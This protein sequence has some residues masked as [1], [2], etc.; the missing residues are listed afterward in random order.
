MARRL[1]FLGLDSLPPR[2]LYGD[3]SGHFRY[4]KGLAGDGARYVMRSCHPPI[5]IPAWLVMLT[6]KSPGELGIYGFRHR[7][8]G[9]YGAHI[10]NS[11]YVRAETLWDSLGK[12]GLRVGLYG[13]PP[14]YPPRPVKGF[15]VSDFTTPDSSAGYT[16][17]PWLKRE[18]EAAVGPPIFDIVYR[19]GDKERAARDVMAMLENHLRQVEYLATAKSW[20][21]FFYVEIAVDRAHH[22]FWRF[23]DPQHPRYEEHPTFSKV[24]PSLYERIDSWFEALH[25]KLPKDTIIVIASDHGT[26]A[27]KGA[28]VVNQWLVEQGFL[29]LKKDLR[30]LKPGTDLQEELVDWGRT[31]AWA[32]GGYYSR[33]FVNVKG[34]EPEGAVEPGAFDEVVEALRS[35]LRSLRGPRGEQWET[36][37]VRPAEVYPRAEGDAPDLMVYFDNLSWRAAGTLG[38]PS[39]YLPEN[40]RGPDDAVHDW[41]GVLAI[42]D[43]EGTV[44]NSDG[45]TLE[46][47]EVRRLLEELVLR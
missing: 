45:G 40:D 31:R 37:A 33:F 3:L 16:F 8:R 42:Y 1:F 19:S 9:G 24:I 27:M 47:H 4:L 36:L 39:N 13:V 15:L 20:D 35:E 32:W 6:G 23:F 44:S 46:A 41:Y 22:A 18:L 2:S 26:K 38:W 25:R 29:K 43:P 21:A 30:E 17:P 14:T 28:F 5:T 7:V 12:R 10:V 34:R 11:H